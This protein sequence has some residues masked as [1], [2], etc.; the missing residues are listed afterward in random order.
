MTK[1]LIDTVNLHKISG[2]TVAIDAYMFMYKMLIN[3]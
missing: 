3:I 1:T 2:K